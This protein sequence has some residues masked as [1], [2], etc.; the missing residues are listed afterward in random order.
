MQCAWAP[1]A[2]M[3]HVSG[4][5]AGSSEGHNAAAAGD[6]HIVVH[7]TRRRAR[8]AACLSAQLLGQRRTARGACSGPRKPSACWLAA[9]APLRTCVEGQ[10][11]RGAPAAAQRHIQRQLRLGPRRRLLL[12]L[13]GR[14]E[15]EAAARNFGEGPLPASSCRQAAG[16]VGSGWLQQA[17][18]RCRPA[19]LPTFLPGRKRM[20]P[21]FLPPLS[22]ATAAEAA[23]ALPAAFSSTAG[24][25]TGTAAA[26]LLLAALGSRSGGTLTAGSWAAGSARRGVGSLGGEKGPVLQRGRVPGG[27]TRRR[28]Q[29]VV[30][31]TLINAAASTCSRCT[32]PAPLTWQPQRWGPPAG[33]WRWRR[34]RRPARRRRP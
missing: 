25:A 15:K 11:R 33:R 5:G 9:P 16:T 27:A 4:S 30:G 1:T 12:G 32:T 18:R 7:C 31:A 17:C 6:V 2:G 29:R 20:A 23:A 14:R 8:R 34:R 13:S 22:A 24:T 26:A 10:A 28:R 19:G 21:F 3:R